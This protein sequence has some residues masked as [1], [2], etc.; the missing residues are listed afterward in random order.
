M[1]F[2]TSGYKFKDLLIASSF[3]RKRPL[4]SYVDGPIL[5]TIF[6]FSKLEAPHLE[7]YIHDIVL[8]W[9]TKTATYWLRETKTPTLDPLN[10]EEG[11]VYVTPSAS[12]KP[13]D[14]HYSYPN[15]MMTK[16]ISSILLSSS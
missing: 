4:S 8:T 16:F 1:K 9:I 12:K 15:H 14:F 5:T 3:F 10:I 13:F 2:L 7:K 6:F 11:P